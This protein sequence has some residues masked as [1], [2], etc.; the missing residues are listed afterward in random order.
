MPKEQL[1]DY[2]HNWYIAN[3]ERILKTRKA[4][5]I[6]NRE[7]IATY[8]KEYRTDNKEKLSI[9]Y[10]AYSLANADKIRAYK[11][12]WY[13]ARRK[14]GVDITGRNEGGRFIKGHKPYGE[15]EKS[16]FWHGGISFEDY[17]REF[18]FKLKETI[19]ERD[20]RICRICEIP[21]NGKRHDCHHADYNKKNN[22]PN[23]IYSLCHSCHLMTNHNRERWSLYFSLENTNA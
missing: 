11:K 17:G 9:F 16:H 7:K 6:V 10:K 19:R 18:N 3:R 2:K 12:I 13:N 14:E 20:G 5:A 23:N 1:A 8:N 4:Y 22:N 15:A 21:E